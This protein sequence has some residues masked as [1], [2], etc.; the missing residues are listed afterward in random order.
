ML[1]I[2]HATNGHQLRLIEEQGHGRRKL[3]RDD[4]ENERLVHEMSDEIDVRLA[5]WIECDKEFEQFEGSEWETMT[6]KLALEWGAKVIHCLKDEVRARREGHIHYLE[7]Y[8]GG[9]L[10]WQSIDVFA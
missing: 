9:H 8:E 5:Q 2:L 6:G 4:E 3:S 10:A 1:D 7:V